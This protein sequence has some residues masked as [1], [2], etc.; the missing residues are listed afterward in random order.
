[1]LALALAE[2]AHDHRL[3][4][5]QGTWVPKGRPLP[6]SF[7]SMLAMCW[8]IAEVE[9]S[10]HTGSVEKSWWLHTGG[11]VEEEYEE[12]GEEDED[13]EGYVT[14]DSVDPDNMTYEARPCACHAC[15]LGWLQRISAGVAGSKQRRFP[16][17]VFSS[18]RIEGAPPGA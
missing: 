14:D 18:V 15:A 7:C 8:Q 16:F 12:Q 11:G 3:A 6:S 5:E 4:Y 17:S 1:M 13:E 9:L 10:I 2:G